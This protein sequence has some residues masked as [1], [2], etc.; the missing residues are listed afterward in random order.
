MV[1]GKIVLNVPLEENLREKQVGSKTKKNPE[2][3]MTAFDTQTTRDIRKF[4]YK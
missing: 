2:I 3:K 1:L 4:D